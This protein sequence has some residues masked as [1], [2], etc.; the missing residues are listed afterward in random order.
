MKNI[1]VTDCDTRREI[2]WLVDSQKVGSRVTET[3]YLNRI[4]IEVQGF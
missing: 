1:L 3:C 4:Y 2:S